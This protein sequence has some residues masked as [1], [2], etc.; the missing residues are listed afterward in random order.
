MR[1]QKYLA[2]CGIGSRRACERLIEERRIR[3]NGEVAQIGQNIDPDTDRLEVDGRPVTPPSN[4]VLV[5]MNKPAGYVTTVQDPQGRPTVMTLL[6]PG[7]PRVFPVGRLDR[8]SEGLLLF[9][10]DGELTNQLLHPS[11]GVWERYVALVTH[12]LSPSTLEQLRR[13]VNLEDGRTSPCKAWMDSG[14][15]V[16]V[17]LKEGR[18]R[19]V[20]RMLGVMGHP[21][22]HLRRVAFGPLQ[23][24]S[25]ALGKVRRVRPE[26]EKELRA[27][28]LHVEPRPAE[29]TTKNRRA[30]LT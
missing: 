4:K 7:L 9:T 25:L 26:E 15:Q 23:I 6:P 22:Q 10:N 28:V 14:N 18:K 17:E 5:M 24:G 16:I 11:R 27:A 8:D 2:E 1:I 30:T 19:Q 20:R 21:V 13:G 12:A 29:D 3:V